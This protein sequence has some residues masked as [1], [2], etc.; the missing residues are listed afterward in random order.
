MESQLAGIMREILS[1]PEEEKDL[2]GRVTS[3]KKE[4]KG[5]NYEAS[6]LIRSLDVAPKTPEV[7]SQNTVELPKMNIPIYI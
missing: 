1:L 2:I 4:M 5:A 3:T 7:P 6:I